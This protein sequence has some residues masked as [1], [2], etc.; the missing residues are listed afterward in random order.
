MCP[1]ISLNL[2]SRQAKTLNSVQGYSSY[3][4]FKKDQ[5]KDQKLPK[6]KIKVKILIR[7]QIKEP[8]RKNYNFFNVAALALE[9]EIPYQWVIITNSNQTM[10]IK[11]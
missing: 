8:T 4:C 6:L 7:K 1:F 10:I 11:K 5:N 3:N 9:M 2:L